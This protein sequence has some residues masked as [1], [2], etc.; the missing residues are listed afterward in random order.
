MVAKVFENRKRDR[1]R[2]RERENKEITAINLKLRGPL[3]TS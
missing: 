1:R 3:N 2:K